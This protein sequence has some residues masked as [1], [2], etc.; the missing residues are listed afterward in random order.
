[1]TEPS[2]KLPSAVIAPKLSAHI[3]LIKPPTLVYRLLSRWR[4]V[5][6]YHSNGVPNAEIEML[7]NELPETLSL[8]NEIDTLD[9]AVNGTATR[10]DITGMVSAMLDAIPTFDPCK[11]VGYLDGLRIALEAENSARSFSPQALAGASLKLLRSERFAPPPDLV[12]ET[13][14]EEQD[15]YSALRDC[16]FRAVC[17]LEEVRRERV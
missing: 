8:R 7:T 6:R 12:I 5:G 14:R 13:V 16:L 3:L 1:M 4:E 17:I 2:A 10:Q 15:K 11:H 9:D